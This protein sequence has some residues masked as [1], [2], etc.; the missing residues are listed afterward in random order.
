MKLPLRVE[1]T[2]TRS[3]FR[4]LLPAAVNH[5]EYA[6]EDGTFVHRDGE[7]GWRIALESMP[8]LRV[9]LIRLERHRVDFDFSGYSAAEIEEFMARF[10]RYF[11]RGGG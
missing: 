11:R 4:R 2:T 3:D 1:M 6:E 10:E 9:G 5:V 8:Q 7:R